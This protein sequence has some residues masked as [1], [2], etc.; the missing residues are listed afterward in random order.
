MKKNISKEKRLQKMKMAQLSTNNKFIIA[1][2]RGHEIHIKES[3]FVIDAIQAV[4]QSANL[5]K[6]LDT[7]YK[8]NSFRKK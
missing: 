4:L 1:P 2:D 5:K 7:I 8:T 6:S 3:I